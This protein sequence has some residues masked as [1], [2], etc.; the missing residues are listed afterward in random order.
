MPCF[1]LPTGISFLIKSTLLFI[2]TTLSEEATER[3]DVGVQ[4]RFLWYG[5]DRQADFGG[6]LEKER[7]SWSERS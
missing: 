4:D 6:K 7:V 2:E 3:G 5:R 1:E